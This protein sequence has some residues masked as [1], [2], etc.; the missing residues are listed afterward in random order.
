MNNH[1][2]RYEIIETLGRGSMGIVYKARDPLIDRL[3]AIKAIDLKVL[4]EEEKARYEA[5]FYQEAKAAGRLNHPNLV[6]I[7]DLGE[8]GDI[9]YIAMEFLEGRD[10]EHQKKVTIDEA[11]NIAIQAA[12]GLHFAHEHGV[13]HRDIKPSNI[14]LLKN[15]L[16]K[17]CDF[18]IARMAS[19]LLHTRTGIILGSPLYMSPEQVRSETVDR[20]SDIF[21]LGI[22]LH[23]MLTG[24][25]P[26]T[27]DTATAVMHRIVHD[28]PGKP[29]ASNPKIPE[30][31]DDIV[32]RCLAKSPADRYQT[33]A[34]LE[35]DLRVCRGMM[36]EAQTGVEH[37]RHYFLSNATA[38]AKK[39]V[40]W[41][42]AGIVV[43][44]AIVSIGLYE[45]VRTLLS[46]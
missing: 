41:K 39:M 18:G 5:R 23:E 12:A 8:T 16:V 3:V 40:K 24:E 13:V 32:A 20:R 43:L 33:A 21:S 19:S 35:H 26:F 37:H 36:L 27:G 14:M 31:L 38:Y 22:V 44:T 2:G 1:L 34:D 6:T 9:A 46:G 25:T 15:N 45:L 10:L 28:A 4:T 17:V 29:S 7:H 42:M 30:L 11:L